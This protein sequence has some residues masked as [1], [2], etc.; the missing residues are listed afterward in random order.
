MAEL[1]DTSVSETIPDTDMVEAVRTVLE[2]SPEPLTLSKIRA[3]LPPRLRSG[4]L[5]DLL[6]RQV[7]ANV[8]VQYPK[9]RSP[10]DRFWDRPMPLHLEFLLRSALQEKPLPWSEIRRKLPDYAKTLAEQVLEEQVARG[11]LYRHPPLSSR[12]GPRFGLAPADPRDY[13]RPELTQAFARLETLGF[14]SPQLREA[15]FD[16]L[17]EEEWAAPRSATPDPGQAAPRETSEDDRS[18]AGTGPV[19]MP[20]V[21]AT[22]EPQP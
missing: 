10:Q 6:R 14:T 12:T 11:L 5:E 19:D 17:R 9:Y 8:F 4:G 21:L 13:L 20:A 18:S 15:A 16:L 2:G 22:S 7:A 3:A 1:I